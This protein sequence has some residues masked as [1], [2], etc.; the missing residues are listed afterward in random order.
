MRRGA[1]PGIVPPAALIISLAPAGASAA[2]L[3][4]QCPGIGPDTRCQYLITVTDEGA[5]LSADQAQGPYERRRGRVGAAPNAS[6][7]AQPKV[8]A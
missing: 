3:Y 6:R 7:P 1:A 4:P 2:P 5:T 8:N